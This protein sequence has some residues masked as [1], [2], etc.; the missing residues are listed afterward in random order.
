MQEALQVMRLSEND[1][2]WSPEIIQMVGR[3]LRVILFQGYSDRKFEIN[4]A[5]FGKIKV[6]ISYHSIAIVVLSFRHFVFSCSFL[7]KK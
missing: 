2:A 3:E 4:S 5:P 1:I 7:R 6:T